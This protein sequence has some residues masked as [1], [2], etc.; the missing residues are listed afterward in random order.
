MGRA[1]ILPHHS[2]IPDPAPLAPL[3]RPATAIDVTIAVAIVIQ[4]LHILDNIYCM[5]YDI[6][7]VIH[8]IYK[9]CTFYIQM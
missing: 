1:R 4:C 9:P 7:Y 2:L 5:M 3:R 6:Y 8:T